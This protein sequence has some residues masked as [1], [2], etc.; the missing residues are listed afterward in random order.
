MR[1]SNIKAGRKLRELLPRT[2]SRTFVFQALG[3]LKRAKNSPQPFISFNLMGWRISGHKMCV[4]SRPCHHN[5]NV[6]RENNLGHNKSITTDYVCLQQQCRP[7]RDDLRPTY[8]G[9]WCRPAASVP[10]QI[11][12]ASARGHYL[13]VPSPAALA[14]RLIGNSSRRPW[15]P[16][17][18]RLASTTKS[19]NNSRTGYPKVPAR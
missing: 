12:A 16:A 11:K 13:S 9:A 17:A 10:R 18:G 8:S 19:P 6:C 7:T 5:D 2:S 14:K 15:L 1:D 4:G 3:A